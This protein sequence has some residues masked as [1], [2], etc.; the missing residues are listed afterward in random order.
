LRIRNLLFRAEFNSRVTIK[1]TG[2]GNPFATQASDDFMRTPHFWDS[3]L[4]SASHL[5]TLLI[6]NLM[7][8][9]AIAILDVAALV[10]HKSVEKLQLWG[11]PLALIEGM[12]ILHACVWVIDALAVLWLCGFAAIQFCKRVTGD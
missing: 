6:D 9:G 1:P 8:I 11:V 3:P 2:K 4:K 7:A 5:W 12:E 10:A